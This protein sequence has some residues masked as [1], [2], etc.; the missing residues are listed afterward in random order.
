MPASHQLAGEALADQIQPLDVNGNPSP[1]GKTVLL[2]IGMSNTTQEFCQPQDTKA[3][4]PWSFMGKAAADP[5]VNHQTLVVVNGAQGGKGSEAWADPTNPTY[6]QVRG[7]LKGTGL[8]ERQ[9]QVVWIKQAKRSDTVP[10]PDP[11]AGA[12][13]LETD[14]AKTLRNIKTFYPN[15][16][17]VFVS[18]RSYGGYSGSGN[19]GEPAA[20]E[21]G[22][23][24]KWLIEA[25]INQMIVGIID[26]RAGDLNYNNG[27]APWIAWGPYLWAD[28]TTPRSD[29]LVWERT[30][31]ESDAT[32]PSRSGET[33]VATELLAF[34][35]TNSLTTRW[36]LGTN[37]TDTSSPTVALTTPAGP[38][39]VSN[40]LTLVAEATDDFGIA[41]VEFLVD[42]IVVGSSKSRPYTFG[43]N[44]VFVPNGKHSISAKAFDTSNHVSTS[45]KISVT[46]AN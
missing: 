9:V 25:Q 1:T 15:V 23:A 26:G 7:R 4:N 18:S 27:T 46:V 16:K 6:S 45:T 39:T 19:G 2:S 14:L 5:E 41:Q 29:G 31:Y 22:F 34:F 35:K 20:Y 32:H 11:N 8:T 13:Q 17:L 33:K 38:T 37:S 43:W 28:G 42:N 10:L 12:Y 40:T 44:T 36:F 30:D 3:C 24:T 21:G